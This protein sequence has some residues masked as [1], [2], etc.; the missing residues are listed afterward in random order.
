M[1]A[2]IP[3][4]LTDPKTT[5][6]IVLENDYT[7]VLGVEW[8]TVTDCFRPM[9]SS[10]SIR[11]VLTK[12]VL[13]SDI[14]RVFDVLGWCSPA[15]IL[16]KILLQRL[17]E[18]NLDWDDPVPEEIKHT[19][20]KWKDELPD[21][22]NHLVPRPYFPKEV[23]VV[24]TQ[25]HGFCDASEVAYSSVVYL[26]AID[27]EGGVH[28]SL[29]MAK[30]KVAPIK[31]LS[32]PR[33][34]LCS[35]VI[36]SK[37]LSHVADVLQIPST[38]IFAWTDSQVVLAWLKG[39][40][41]RFKPFV[42]NRI[43]EISEALP[44]GCWRHVRG[45]ENPADCASRGMFPSQLAQ[46][47]L[48]WHGPQWLK[49]EVKGWAPDV[50]FPEHPIPSE[51]KELQQ[52]VL[53]AQPVDLPL[54]KEVSNYTR[55]R[56]ITAWAFRFGRNCRK[57]DRIMNPILTVRELEQAEEFWCR[58][59]QRSAFLEDIMNLET[60]G[61]L[62]QTS[63]LLTF[64]PFLDP[65]GLLRV[66]GRIGRANLPYAKRHPILLPRSHAFTE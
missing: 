43:A 24:S 49:D 54:L 1:L 40:P 22:R 57:N 32:I 27:S 50:E 17:W 29:V 42:G 44:V 46:H 28:T 52:N 48:W 14:A 5:Q 10:P 16:L 26:R 63:K 11:T 45:T 30:T 18:R 33:L 61:R 2:S 3:E 12:R 51:E 25:L 6:E 34:E 65:K 58:T 7:K 66:G 41:R 20:T 31:R 36:L 47:D 15:I 64:H 35:G 56:R 53:A 38:N 62:R 8:N 37:V 59:T 19:W 9:I 13:V 39:N 4:D 60:K 21:L 55:L 23:K